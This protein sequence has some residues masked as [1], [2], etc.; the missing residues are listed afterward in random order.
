MCLLGGDKCFEEKLRSGER[1]EVQAG[2]PQF[3]YRV[4]RTAA[5]REALC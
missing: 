1:W 3:P 4:V 2:T 5:R